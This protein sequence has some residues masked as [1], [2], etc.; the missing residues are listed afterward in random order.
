M[1]R[2]YKAADAS[3]DAFIQR[4][5]FAKLLSYLVYFNNLWHKFDE[6]D[7]DGDRRLDLPEFAQGCAT[8]G[9]E[10]SDAEAAVEFAVVDRDGGGMILFEEFCVWSAGWSGGHL[11]FEGPA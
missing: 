10:L 5:E 8:L 7:S 2:A 9:L 1:L 4:V 6:I 11:A 3:G